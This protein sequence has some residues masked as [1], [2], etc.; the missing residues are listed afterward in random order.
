MS[1]ESSKP[2][3]R[4]ASKKGNDQ[5]KANLKP[6]KPPAAMAPVTPGGQVAPIKVP[7]DQPIP[8]AAATQEAM[9]RM[10]LEEK[11]A[12]QETFNSARLSTASGAAV[13]EEEEDNM[14]IADD[15]SNPGSST[16]KKTLGDDGTQAFKLAKSDPLGVITTKYP[17][18]VE[19]A[20]ATVLEHLKGSEQGVTALLS[21]IQNGLIVSPAVALKHRSDMYSSE[22]RLGHQKRQIES[23]QSELSA[24]KQRSGDIVKA[25]L[26]TLA[27]RKDDGQMGVVTP[28]TQQKLTAT[29]DRLERVAGLMLTARDNAQ[30]MGSLKGYLGSIQ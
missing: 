10:S 20:L 12:L 1:S 17:E 25:T 29:P 18:V 27:F 21:A 23:L 5:S 4:S 16:F 22:E 8:S 30:L 3:T 6:P 28:A 2:S 9:S 15:L 26:R 19:G 7:D 14:V 13:A 24:S 11:K